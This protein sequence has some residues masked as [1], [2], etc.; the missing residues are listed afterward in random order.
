MNNYKKV[1]VALELSQETDKNLLDAAKSFMDQGAEV[2]FIHAVEHLINYGTAYGLSID[3]DIESE[4]LQESEKKMKKQLSNLCCSKESQIIRFGPAKFMILNEAEVLECDLIL[5][6]SH[7]HHGVRLLLGSTANSILHGAACDVLAVRIP[8]QRHNQD[9]QI[10]LF[11]L[12]GGGQKEQNT[13]NTLT[14]PSDD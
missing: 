12:L 9:T 6:G 10:T 1:L 2:Y 3:L 7:G 11:C 8:N 13:D 5:V 4:L 14:S